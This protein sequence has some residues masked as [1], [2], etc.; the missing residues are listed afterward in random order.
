MIQAKR[1]GVFSKCDVYPGA[2]LVVPAGVVPYALKPE[3]KTE[4]RH[5]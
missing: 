3:R 4:S 2:G 1:Q 5:E